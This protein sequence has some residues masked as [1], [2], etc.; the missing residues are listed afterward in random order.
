MT[1]QPTDQEEVRRKVRLAHEAVLAAGQALCAC[2][3]WTMADTIRFA[4]EV[5]ERMGTDM[6]QYEKVRLR[7]QQEAIVNG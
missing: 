3:M 1:A 5:L 7:R 2:G 6:N 4:A